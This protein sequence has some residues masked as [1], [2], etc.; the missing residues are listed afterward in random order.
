MPFLT[1][2][3]IT[4][5]V[6]IEGGASEWE[7]QADSGRGA[8][9]DYLSTVASSRRAWTIGLR[10]LSTREANA[11]ERLA[12][13]LGHRFAFVDNFSSKGLNGVTTGSVTP[14][15]ASGKFD[16]R[17]TLTSTSTIAWTFG[18]DRA[19]GLVADYTISVWHLDTGVWHHYL[20]R[21][22]AA[23]AQPL[24]WFLDGV[25]QGAAVLGAGSLAWLAV[26]LTLGK[27]TLTAT[28]GVSHAWSEMVVHPFAIGAD[29]GEWVTSFS[30]AT[31][32]HPDLPTLR[33]AGDLAIANGASSLSV[34]VAP[35]SVKTKPKGFVVSGTWDKAAREVE[36]AMHEV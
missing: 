19:H 18:T 25:D 8:N 29:S 20:I 5:P 16:K 12:K 13:G 7:D 1:L 4:C 33:A 23:H 14:N 3:G 32:A 28:G 6:D 35:D 27:L 15:G 22:C 34:E 9:G 26:D 36:F 31:V 17:I 21:A 11:W 24:K 30:G 2:N 10:T